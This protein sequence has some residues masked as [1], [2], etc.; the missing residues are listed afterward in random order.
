MGDGEVP[1]DV[2][3]SFDPAIDFYEGDGRFSPNG[4]WIA[5]VS[6]ES[7]RPEIY[8]QAFPGPGNPVV[9]S[10]EGGSQP[11]WRA[12][13]GRELF[14]MSPDNHLMVVPISFAGSRIDHGKAGALFPV[15]A[16]SRL[17]KP[18]GASSN[19]RPVPSGQNQSPGEIRSPA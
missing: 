11:M 3:V 15:R 5:Y 2:I 7:G 17:E 1:P 19:V 14:Y 4:R 8:V 6:E 10:V 16:G 9:M 12:N 13:D 18:A